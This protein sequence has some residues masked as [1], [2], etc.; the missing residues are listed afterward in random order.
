MGVARALVTLESALRRRRPEA[1]WE[2]EWLQAV[3]AGRFMTMDADGTAIGAA[4]TP[5]VLVAPCANLATL[6]ALAV[7]GPLRLALKVNPITA[8]KCE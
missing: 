5:I 7:A 1:A 2:N 8:L 3:P 4:F 6:G